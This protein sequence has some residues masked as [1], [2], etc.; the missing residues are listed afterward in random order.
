MENKTFCCIITCVY[1]DIQELCCT[2]HDDNITPN[3]E[4]IH[5]LECKTLCEEKNCINEINF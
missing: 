2:K 1:N 5:L 3:G 4:C